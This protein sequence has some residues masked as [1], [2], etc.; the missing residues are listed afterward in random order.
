MAREILNLTILLNL[1]AFYYHSK[2]FYEDNQKNK[3]VI[4]KKIKP[5]TPFSANICI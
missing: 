2:S 3:K 4:N 1:N 5:I